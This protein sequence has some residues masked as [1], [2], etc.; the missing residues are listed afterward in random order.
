[1]T[2]AQALEIIGRLEAVDNASPALVGWEPQC[3]PVP[4]DVEEH[5]IFLASLAV[6]ARAA[7]RPMVIVRLRGWV[8]LWEPA[9]N[10]D[11]WKA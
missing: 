9:K 3:D 4:C 11:F 5:A 10:S 8:Q 7:R 2:M 6:D 1:M